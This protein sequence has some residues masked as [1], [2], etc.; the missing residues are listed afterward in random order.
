MNT[1][2]PNRQTLANR[3]NAA[4]STGPRTAEGKAASSQNALRTGLT[5]RTVLLPGDDAEAYE[6]HIQRFACELQPAGDRELE[7]VQSLADTQWRLIRIPALE[8][9]IYALGAHEFA[10]L[11]VDESAGVRKALI[12]ARTYLAYTRQLNNLHLQES[13]LRRQYEKDLAELRK[14]QSDRK[15]DELLQPAPDTQTQMASNFQAANAGLSLPGNVASEALGVLPD[16]Q[17]VAGPSEH[18]A[19]HGRG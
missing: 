6:R 4:F 9:G 10:D 15:V 13:R 5:G 16:H 19:Q 11:Y 17:D 18:I 12:Q 3:H 14:L 2:P 8:A 7:L 1:T